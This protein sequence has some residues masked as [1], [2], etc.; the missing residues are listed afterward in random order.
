[1]A[2]ERPGLMRQYDLV[3]VG[4]AMLRLSVPSGDLLIDAPRF[5]VHVAGSECNVAAAC[6]AMGL[7]SAWL[8][9][10]TDNPLG[11]RIERTLFAHHVDTSLI[12]WTDQ[13]RIGV[14]YLEHGADPRPTRVVYDRLPS[15]ARGM[16][17]STFDPA[18]FQTAHVLHLTGITAALGSGP[19]ELLQ[20][21]I[22]TAKAAGTLVVFD[23]NYRAL[24]WSVEDCAA[25]LQPLLEQAD[26]IIGA[27]RDMAAI[28]GL[29]AP[30]ETPVQIAAMT[31]ERFGARFAC[32]TDS[33]HGA[34]AYSAVTGLL[35]VPGYA[36][37]VVDR[38]GAGDAFAAGV[39]TGLCEGDF[40]RGLEYG[41]AMSALQLTTQGD[42][43]RFSRA[44]VE[45][46]MGG[47]STAHP[48]R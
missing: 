29:N 38:L 46:V 3:T 1:M 22:Q 36:V 23:V 28:F 7:R 15:S 26:V 21:A 10:L 31:S 39:I 32:V 2:S 6:G 30:E 43:F 18:I 5:D 16:K 37:K 27:R 20:M 19:L 33:Q 8:S 24:L 44:D 35:H 13:G 48:V 12:R 11:Q 40:T 17:G 14:F 9:R 4:E 25:A 34:Y 42:L 47:N 41:V 45:Q